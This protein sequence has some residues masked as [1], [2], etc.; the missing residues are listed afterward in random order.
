MAM[1]HSSGLEAL[2]RV[3]PDAV[4]TVGNYDGVHLGHKRLLERC[5][6]LSGDSAPVVVVTF[7]PHPLTRLRPQFAPPR[8]TPPAVKARLLEEQGVDML[9]ELPPDPEVLSI[10]AREF[11]DL[12]A[13]K[14]RVRHL[15]EGPDFSFGKGREGNIS[16]LRAWS[17]GT[18]MEVHAVEEL[19]A[20]LTN[21]HLVEVRSSMIRWLIAYGRVRDAAICIGRP[22]SIRGLIVKGFQR[23]RQMGMPTAN[24]G[25][26]EQ[27]VPADGVYA[28]RCTVGGKTY[29]AGVSIGTLP[30]FNETKRQVE[31]H[32]LGFDG[33]L[34][35]QTLDLELID[36]VRDQV[37]FNGIEQLKEK[38]WRDMEVC[39]RLA[40]TDPARPIAA[41]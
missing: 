20:V 18:T 37:K 28:G 9:V 40:Q 3:P 24:F 29:A 32:L 6:E 5:R 12:L 14:L 21:L 34:Y 27:L 13:N 30:T 2:K 19:N 26:I 31:A 17:A 33:D 41:A 23:G 36:F 11:F 7:E 1:L 4:M 22:Y 25:Q 15:V 10:S 8:L 35:G 38:M 39:K 16:N